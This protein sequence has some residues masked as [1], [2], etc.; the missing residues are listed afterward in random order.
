MMAELDP[1]FFKIACNIIKRSI[2]RKVDKYSPKALGYDVK[3]SLKEYREELFQDFIT[4]NFMER[5][6][7]YYESWKKS[8]RDRFVNYI[9]ISIDRY[10]Q[11]K[12]SQRNP[13]SNNLWRN[14]TE[15]L[16]KLSEE[17]VIELREY[18]ARL[19]SEDVVS[20][21]SLV[22]PDVILSVFREL[23]YSLLKNL[24]KE[25]NSGVRINKEELKKLLKLI[26]AKV[27]GWVYFE[28]LQSALESNNPLF[29]DAVDADTE[30]SSPKHDE[31]D[32]ILNPLE[33]IPSPAPTIEE[34]LIE[35]EKSLEKRIR[36][37]QFHNVLSDRQMRIYELVTDK[38]AN[39]DK[40]L[41]YKEISE[42]LKSENMGC[43]LSTVQRE[44]K[45]IEKIYQ[46]IM[47]KEEDD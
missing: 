3:L 16:R 19:C 27:D 30:A 42:I 36:L 24:V 32:E 20:R 12:K 9:G 37:K 29:R 6:E 40:K 33:N 38:R 47:Q 8:E 22:S 45:R 35:R 41:T 21:A 7:T 28:N 13:R 43:D 34:V 17:R 15:C 4:Y 1:D 46:N 31:R 2:Y 11:R 10:L 18:R 25:T 14:M 44:C 5:R 39:K 23:D 26:L